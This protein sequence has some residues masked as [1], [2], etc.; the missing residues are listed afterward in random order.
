[1]KVAIIED[2]IPAREQL[3][4]LLSKI[5]SDLEVVFTAQSIREAVTH[6][7]N[8][9]TLDLIFLDIQLNDG[10]SL[11]IFNHVSVNAPVIFATAFD[12]YTLQAFQQ[13]GIDYLLKPIKQKELE[14]ALAK[15]DQLQAH[16]QKDIRRLIDSFQGMTTSYRQRVLVR[17]GASYS[18]IP[19]AEVQYFFSE[20]KVTFLVTAAG[21]RLIVDETLADLEASLSPDQFY[22]LNRAVLASVGSIDKFTSDGKGKLLV[23]LTPPTKEVVTVSQEKASDFKEWISR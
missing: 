3:I 14:Q 10:L 13:N 19:L 21:L 15:F 12:Q 16:F 17:K 23:D 2:E 8:Q 11:D 1:M 20:H 7:R 4:S 9:P 5:R 18:S 22:R 6:F